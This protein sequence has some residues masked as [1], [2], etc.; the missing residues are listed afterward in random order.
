M[1]FMAFTVYK[2]LFKCLSLSVLLISYTSKG[3]ANT[4]VHDHNIIFPLIGEDV[5]Q[6]L[7]VLDN[8]E[9]CIADLLLS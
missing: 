2:N 5:I 7:C 6:K 9:I 8:D 3:F 1:V 4:S